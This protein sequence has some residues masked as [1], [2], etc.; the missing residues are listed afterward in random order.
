MEEED[1]EE[2]GGGEDDEKR[3]SSPSVIENT[4]LSVEEQ[5]RCSSESRDLTT[6]RAT[7]SLCRAAVK[8]RTSVRFYSL[9]P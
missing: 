8:C 1:G 9:V 4:S 6:V 5:V 2:G 7:F 3:E